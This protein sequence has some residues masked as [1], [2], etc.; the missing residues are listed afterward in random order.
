MDIATQSKKFLCID[1]ERSQLMIVKQI[2]SKSFSTDALTVYEADSG[3]AGL[4]QIE[5]L[6]PDIIL[7]DIHMPGI[8][9][10]EVCRRTREKFPGTAVI[11]MS[12]YDEEEDNASRAREV[13]ADSFLSKPVKKGELLFVVGYVLRVAHLND[14]LFEKNRQLEDSLDRLKQFHQKL[15]VLNDELQADK[16]RLNTN[17]KEMMDLNAQLE[18]KNSQISTMMTEMSSRFDS[19]VGLLANIIDLRQ[20]Q[21]KGHSERVAQISLFIAGKLKLTDMQ[22]DTIKVAARLHELGIVSLPTQEKK[23]LALDEEK[24]R[25]VSNHPLVGEM[26][27]KSFP[28]FELVAD[29]I[30]HLHENYDGSGAPDGL[31]GDRIPIGSRIISAASFFDHSAQANSKSTPRQVMEKMMAQGGVW[32]DEQ[33][34]SCL[35]DYVDSQDKS[36]REKLIDCTVFS[37]SEGMVLASD[38]YS[39]SGI[40]LLR[41]GTLLNKDILSKILKFHK[42]DPISGSIKVKQG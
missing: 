32:F 38:I 19:T 35:S 11:L 42:M 7:C 8:D 15:S 29:I 41:K 27:L 26:L 1:D 3:E 20:S 16:S 31:F 39:D 2:L 30:R 40:N 28:G 34:L 24:G 10:Y 37:L 5:E 18:N 4:K 22:K 14:A 33:V 6:T 12:A 9:G 25:M 23:Q 13:G 17:L 36:L 21:H